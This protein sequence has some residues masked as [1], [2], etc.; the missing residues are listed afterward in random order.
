MTCSQ[1]FHSLFTIYSWL[2]WTYSW[3]DHNFFT[4]IPILFMMCSWLVHL[5]T[6]SFVPVH[7]LFMTCFQLVH[8]LFTIFH[9]LFTLLLPCSRIIHSFF[10][11]YSQLIHNC[12]GLVNLLPSS[13]QAPTPTQLGAE[14]ALFPVWSSHP[15]ATHPRRNSRF[16]V[17][18]SYSCSLTCLWLVQNL[19]TT[20]SWLSYNILRTC[21]FIRITLLSLLYIDLLN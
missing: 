5:S 19:F 4:I 14:F 15:P 3:F 6:T 18:Y 13:A 2:F 11:I 8:S 17:S 7:H 1:L 21:F 12:S 20:S 16:F 9:S 10:T